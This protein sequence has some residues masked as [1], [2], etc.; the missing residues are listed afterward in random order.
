MEYGNIEREIRIDASPEVVYD[1]IS[2]PEHIK[3]W[4]DAD[5]EIEPVVGSV[6]R[7]QWGTSGRSA[8]MVVVEATPGQVFA[9]RWIAPPG[10]PVD[11]DT[12]LTAE[13][14]VLVTFE[15]T[16]HEDGTLLKVTEGAMREL[17]WE[18]AL[19]EE[20]F[21]GHSDG[22]SDLLPAIAARATQL[23]AA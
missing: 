2:T 8:R 9:F 17:G 11:D 16:A 7:L 19:L 20:Y 4:F 3:V 5:A 14:S 10:I 15:L 18:A 12:E 6:G 13:N 22:W 1:V 21:L 23:A